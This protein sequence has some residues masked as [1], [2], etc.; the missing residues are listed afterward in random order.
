MKERLRKILFPHPLL[1]AVLTALSTA[2][3]VWTFAG[4]NENSPLAYLYYIT[5]AYTLTALCARVPGICRQGRERV[6]RN[7]LAAR[8]LDDLHFRARV[9]LWLSLGLNGLFG[10]FKLGVGALL[11]SWWELT[12]GVYYIVLAI[13][14]FFLLW[15]WEPGADPAGEEKKRRRCGWLL[16]VLVAPLAGMAAMIVVDGYGKSYPG[17][18]IY[19]AA[20]YTFY[21][22]ISA[23]AALC[24]RGR[25][26][27]LTAAKTLKLTSALVSL[28]GLQTA[29]FAAFGGDEGFQRLMNAATGAGVCA[30]IFLLGVWTLRARQRKRSK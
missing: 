18:L 19:A 17:Y 23:G 25:G 26:A 24:R 11:G 4:G 27:V 2:G 10:L 1:L 3:L 9:S 12:F 7:A 28:L 13:A 30:L 8:W 21:N 6:E 20:A 22:V 14:R 5:S 15:R 29:M 16:L